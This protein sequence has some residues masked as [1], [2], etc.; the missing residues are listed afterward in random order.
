MKLFNL[1]IYLGVLI[2]TFN[3]CV[4]TTP[5]PSETPVIDSSLP[6]VT[7]SKAGV[8]TDMKA[9]GFEW[10]SMKDP[11]VK[12]IYVYKKSFAQELTE[13]EFQ[14]TINNRFVTHYID[15]NVQPQSKYAY[16]FKT[17]T[18][19][20][21]SNPSKEIVVNTLP[22]LESVSWIHAVANM[23]RSAKI[24]WRPHTNQIVKRYILERK[25]LEEDKWSELE[26]INGR[27]NAEY[28]D[29]DLKD[30]FVYKYRIK[31]L[32]Y[33]GITSKPSQEVKIVTKALPRAVENIRATKNL[34]KQIKLIWE[35]VVVE[36]FSHYNIYRAERIDGNYD[37][38]LKAQDLE[39]VDKIEEDGKNYF[40]RVSTVDK[41]DL[42]S[43]YTLKSAHGKSLSKPI[44]P[45]LVEAQ[46]LGDNL[47]INWNSTDPRVKTFVV[48]K[49][50]KFSWINITNEDFVGIKGT[51]FI[52]TSVAPE[53]TYTYEVYS[54]D[55]FGIVSEPSIQVK[56]TTTKE[57]GKIPVAKDENITPP[58]SEVTVPQDIQNVVQPM[59]DLDV[60]SL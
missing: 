60:S 7:L 52:D 9:V 54:V 18:Q 34:P 38:V 21:E 29:E 22:V 42:Q 40:Y 46:M 8:F 10:E 37:L 33:N 47:E 27:L 36:D 12:G 58:Q 17:F 1:T 20:S 15:E 53:T 30:N 26:S 44:T 43:E 41:D 24:I 3:A 49:K 32:T 13:Y 4:G 23:P 55:E 2:L 19:N 28:I 51:S 59:D 25:T 48:R 16:Y 45:S 39:F 6:V 35:R 31:V 11:R 57:E 56:Y 5:S 50:S 14:E